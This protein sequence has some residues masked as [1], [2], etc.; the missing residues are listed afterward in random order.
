MEFLIE[1]DVYT[2][3]PKEIQVYHETKKNS[4]VYLLFINCLMFKNLWFSFNLFVSCSSVF[5]NDLLINLC[6]LNYYL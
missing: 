3:K 5:E 4:F 2:R 6:D 1:E